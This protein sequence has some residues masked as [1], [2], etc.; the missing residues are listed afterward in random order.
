[1]STGE[2]MREGLRFFLS[3]GWKYFVWSLVLLAVC[4]ALSAVAVLLQHGMMDGLPRRRADRAFAELDRDWRAFRWLLRE[5]RLSA[6]GRCLRGLLSSWM[7]WQNQTQV[8]RV[9]TGLVGALAAVSVVLFATNLV[10]LVL[11]CV[12]LFLNG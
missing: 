8:G 3:G 6:L 5:R 10:Q 9:G 4:A 1:M 12:R 11:A 7:N 2:A